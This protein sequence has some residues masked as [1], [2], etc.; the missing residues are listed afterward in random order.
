MSEKQQEL[1]LMILGVVLVTVVVGAITLNVM[2]KEID[3]FIT[4]IGFA[5]LT[6]ITALLV[7]PASDGKPQPVEVTN[8]GEGAPQK[9]EVINVT[10]QQVEVVNEAVPVVETDMT[11]AEIQASR[12]NARGQF[13]RKDNA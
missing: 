13:A 11:R 4:A 12:R 10:P 5:A 6:S 9:V 8:R 7:K 2:D 3:A 1:V